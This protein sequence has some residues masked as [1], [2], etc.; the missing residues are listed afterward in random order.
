MPEDANPSLNKSSAENL[1]FF[2]LPMALN[3]QRNSY[4]LWESALATWNDEETK[5]VFN[6]QAVIKMSDEELKQKLVKHKVALQ[7]NKQPIIWR[8]LCQTTISEFDCDLRNL[9]IANDGNIIKIKEYI[10]SNKK[11]FPYLSGSKILNYW[12]YVV[13]SYTN[14]KQTNREAITIAPD[15]HVLQASM[16]LGV[17]A[18]SELNKSNIREVTSERWADILKGTSLLPIDLHTPFWLWSRNDF[19]IEI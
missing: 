10:V 17:I 16:K 9:F 5:E 19:K 8:T 13:G 3:Y 2:T 7:P 11:K 4:K 14:M 12:L 15:T 18:E 1:L 6:P